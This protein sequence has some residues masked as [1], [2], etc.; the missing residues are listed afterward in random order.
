[1]FDLSLMPLWTT[2]TR[3]ISILESDEVRIVRYTTLHPLCYECCRMCLAKLSQMICC[4]GKLI[5]AISFCLTCVDA[6]LSTQITGR[7]TL[8]Q[9]GHEG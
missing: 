9:S 7:T 8:L 2:E 3:L 5:V 6:T 4:H 1:M